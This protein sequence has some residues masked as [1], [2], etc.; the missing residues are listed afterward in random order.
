MDRAR[1]R[2]VASR[3]VRRVLGYTGYFQLYSVPMRVLPMLDYTEKKDIYQA[4]GI[5]GGQPTV[6]DHLR[7]EGLPFHMSDWRK[8]ERDNLEKAYQ[9][10]GLGRVR[11]IYLYLAELDGI[12]HAHGTRTGWRIR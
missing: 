9:A 3:A 6:F 8:S 2:N 1:V 10:A 4:G 5:N 7:R 11:A 12:M